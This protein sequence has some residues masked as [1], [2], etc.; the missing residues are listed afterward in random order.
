MAR[1]KLLGTHDCLL[2]HFEK[3]KKVTNLK[4]ALCWGRVI[5]MTHWHS[6]V[7]ASFENNRAFPPIV[8][9]AHKHGSLKCFL[10]MRNCKRPATAVYMWFSE[11]HFGERERVRDRDRKT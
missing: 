3:K 11:Q 5:N 10:G 1:K 4:L 7:F 9:C 6:R 8:C 2:S